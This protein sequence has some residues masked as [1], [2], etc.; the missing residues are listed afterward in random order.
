VKGQKI[1]LT[2]DTWTSKANETYTAGT[3]HFIDDNWRLNSIVFGCFPRSGKTC[4]LDHLRVT[5]EHL[6]KFGIS[7]DNIVCT[8]TNSDATMC[9][10]GR[11]L[12]TEAK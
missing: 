1:S 11:E 8:T 7:I 10:L 9:S 5:Q 3:G 12:V 4:A 2:T 6:Q